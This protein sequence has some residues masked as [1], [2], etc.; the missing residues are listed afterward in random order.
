[1]NEKVAKIMKAL[2]VDEQTALEI[3]ESDVRIDKG[4]PLF[5]LTP[6]QK[7]VEKEMR[8]TGTRT[9]TVYKFDKRTRKADEDKRELIRLLENAV[10]GVSET[11]VEVANPERELLFVYKGKKYKIVLSAPRS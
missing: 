11:L 5:E 10:C 8:G 2:Q 4:E 3:I 9:Q 6:N 7:R 1:M